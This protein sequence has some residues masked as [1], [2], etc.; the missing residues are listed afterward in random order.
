MS[1]V[2]LDTEMVDR[3]GREWIVTGGGI[4]LR[5]RMRVPNAELR[6][7]PIDSDVARFLRRHV[8]WARVVRG[9]PQK[10]EVGTE[11]CWK[12]F[13]GLCEASPFAEFYRRLFPD[14]IEHILVTRFEV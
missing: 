7:L 12:T 2:R 5:D 1:R 11:F 6:A 14:G 3:E 8:F 10:I 4:V 9:R 13:E